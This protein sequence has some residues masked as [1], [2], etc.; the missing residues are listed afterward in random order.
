[1]KKE[2]QLYV[3]ELQGTGMSLIRAINEKAADR[4]GKQ[5]I[6]DRFYGGVHLASEAEIQG[7]KAMGGRTP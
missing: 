2:S 1:M 3:V 4:I 5:F 7:F 6:L